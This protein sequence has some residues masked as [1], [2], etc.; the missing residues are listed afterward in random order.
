MVS[1]QF[2]ISAER[3]MRKM[4]IILMTHHSSLPPPT[5]TDKPKSEIGFDP[6]YPNDALCGGELHRP[7]NGSILLIP[8]GSL[9]GSLARQIQKAARA[10]VLEQGSFEDE[11][12]R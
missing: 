7:L 10:S 3:L 12:L 9:G 5:A 6:S 4:V 1:I 11:N 8:I 2:G